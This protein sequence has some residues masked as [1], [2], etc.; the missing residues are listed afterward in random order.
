MDGPTPRTGATGAAGP[1][2]RRSSAFSSCDD[3]RAQT[4][5]ASGED[6]SGV[7]PAQ[8]VDPARC[9]AGPV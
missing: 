3:E 9:V 4:L 6:G 7:G 2:R 1:P 8:A 5:R